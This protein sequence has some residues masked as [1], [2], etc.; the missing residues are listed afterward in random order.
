[1]NPP[2]PNCSAHWQQEQSK[3]N[4]ENVPAH[5]AAHLPWGRRGQAISGDRRCWPPVLLFST[6][7]TELLLVCKMTESKHVLGTE[8]VRTCHSPLEPLSF[9]KSYSFRNN[10]SKYLI[11]CDI[12]PLQNSLLDQLLTVFKPHIWVSAGQICNSDTAKATVCNYHICKNVLLHICSNCHQ[13]NIQA[14]PPI[15]IYRN[16]IFLCFSATL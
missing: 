16:F 9:S 5:Q 11:L 15:I 7:P 14:I 2:L 13:P 10:D 12:I 3:A 8:Q 6:A 1:M 4:S